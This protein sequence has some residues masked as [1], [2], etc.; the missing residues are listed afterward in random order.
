MDPQCGAAGS[1]CLRSGTPPLIC[2]PPACSLLCSRLPG[3]RFCC[4]SAPLVMSGTSISSF[5]PLVVPLP[6]LVSKSGEHPSWGP[7]GNGLDTAYNEMLRFL[8]LPAQM[9]VL[10]ISLFIASSKVCPDVPDE[11]QT[12]FPPHLPIPLQTCSYSYVHRCG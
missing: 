3:P 4:V 8:L 12:H 7:L 6:G 5:S 10:R 11:L 9:S 1:D 2:S